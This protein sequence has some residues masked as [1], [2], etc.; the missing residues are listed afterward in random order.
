MLMTTPLPAHA[1][2]PI[3]RRLAALAHPVRPHVWRSALTLDLSKA[4]FAVPVR[5]GVAVGGVLIVGGLLGLTDIAGFAALGALVAAFCRPDPY[6][7][8]SGRL[9]ALGVGMVLA[10]LVGAVIGVSG[11][12]LVTEIVVIALL[13][14]AAAA[15]IASVRIAGPGAVVFV[16]AAAAAAGAVHDAAGLGRAVAATAVGAA[17]GMLASMAP[18]LW[19]NLIRA[20][21]HDDSADPDAPTVQYES[22][23]TAVGRV[24]ET[25]LVINAARTMAAAAASAAIAAAAGFAHPLWAAMGAVAALQGITYHVTVTRG[26]ARLLGNVAGAAIAAALLAVPLGFWGAVVAIILFQTIAE[27]NAPVNYTVASSVVTPMALLLTALGAGLSP[28]AA[29]DRVADT[30][31]GIV[32]G[33]VIAALTITPHD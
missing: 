13:A 1:A 26:L 15:F 8:R 23:F 3:R 9:A 4:S 31:I 18:W 10:T 27:I 7:V 28:A 20:L 32:V 11:G 22:V 30:L 25:P 17:C 12:A 6:R 24:R 5:V 29:I 14:G 19:R 2:Q 21:R 33:I 16:F